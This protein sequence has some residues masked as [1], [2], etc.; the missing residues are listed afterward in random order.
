[1]LSFRSFN[2]FRSLINFEFVFVSCMKKCF[3]LIV[4]HVAFQFSQHH[5][6]KR[7][8]FLYYLFSCLLCYRL[9]DHKYV[10][11]FLS[12]IFCSI[13]LWVCFCVSIIPSWL[14]WLG[15][16]V[17]SQEPWYLQL[18]SFSKLFGKLGSFVVPH[19]L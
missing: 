7:L 12:F 11:L 5:L 2:G 16:I 3:N 9:I 10:C 19:V 14:S 8:S 1:M 4:L 18:C 6:L 15:S 17:W 13:D